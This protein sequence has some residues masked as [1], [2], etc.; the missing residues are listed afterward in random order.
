MKTTAQNNTGEPSRDTEIRMQLLEKDLTTRTKWFPKTKKKKK[1]R[2][3]SCCKTQVRKDTQ[4]EHFS[5]FASRA[6]FEK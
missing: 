4:Q 6:F 5:V 1:K 3:P 2:N